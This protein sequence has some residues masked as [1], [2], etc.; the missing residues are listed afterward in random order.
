MSH[1]KWMPDPN[2]AFPSVKEE[3]RC[4]CLRRPALM[5]VVLVLLATIQASAQQAFIT[6]KEFH[7]K[8]QKYAGQTVRLL[9]VIAHYRER[10]FRG[11]P[12]TIFLLQDLELTSGSR[13]FDDMAV[14]AWRRPGPRAFFDGQLVVVTGRLKENLWV[15]V[16]EGT[17]IL[18]LRPKEET[19]HLDIPQAAVD[20]MDY[21]G[22]AVGGIRF[23]WTLRNPSH[24][25]GAVV[26]FFSEP[27]DVHVTYGKSARGQGQTSICT[28]IFA[29]NRLS[30]TIVIEIQYVVE[31]K[32]LFHAEQI[33]RFP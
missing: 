10:L 23:A 11:L 5:V 32:D 22:C 18:T 20:F 1:I 8:A 24:V 26:E 30:S 14:I 4:V 29:T 19:R 25:H 31:L 33:E 2:A 3:L 7:E 16:D 9:G 12:Y 28:P 15:R 17:F 27:Q 21:G 13:S 6:P